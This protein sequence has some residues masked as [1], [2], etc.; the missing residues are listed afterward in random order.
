MVVAEQ[1]QA[2][3][4]HHVRPVG[5]KRLTLFLRFFLNDLT[6]DDQIT[7]QR[8]LNARRGFKREREHVGGFIFPAIGQVELM[9]FRVIDQTNGY[10][11]LFLK[12]RDHRI[13]PPLKLTFC[14]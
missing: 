9:A 11:R 13:Q 2:T 10:F 8:H 6:A 7:Q 5:F 1:M 12:L 4:H 14:G 3:M